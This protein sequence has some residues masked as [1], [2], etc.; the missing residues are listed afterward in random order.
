MI[1]EKVIDHAV[2]TPNNIAIVDDK[3][4]LTYRELVYGANLFVDHLESLAPRE[5]FGE[6]VGLLIPPTAA[7]VVAFGG[8]RWADRVALPLNYLLKPDELVGVVK[9]AGLKILFTIEFFKPLAEAVA[10]QTGV[11]VVYMESL[12][13]EK[14]GMAVM[15]SIAMS[16]ANLRKHLKP[17]PARKP[18]DV[19]VIMYTSGTSGVPKGVMLT[20][21]NLESNARD[22]CQHA[23]F[24]EKTVF[25]GVIP[26]FHTLGMMGTML[27]PLMLGSKVVYIARFSPM[28]VF[29][30]VKQHGIEVL[31]MVPTMYAVMASAK[32]A[33]P[34]SLHGVRYVISGGE[35]LP[36]T[37]IEQFKEKFNLTLMEGFG[38]TETSPIVALNVPWAYKLGSVGKIIPEVQVK[39]VDDQ[40][41]DLPVNAD[42]GELYIK[43]PNV[44][45][46]YYNRPEVTAEVMTADGWFKT[47]DIAKMDNEG[48]LYITGRKKDMI[49]M[50]GEKVFPREI[51]DAIKQHPAVLLV[52]VIGMKDE[53]RGEAPV[54]FVQLKPEAGQAGGNL[55]KPT[56]QEIRAF[57]RERIAPY[58]TPRDV[59]FLDELP[60]TPT[61]KVLKR[62]LKVPG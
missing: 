62:A 8:T 30:S 9:D 1:L 16:A 33:R 11:K 12:K 38:L 43:G 59:Y 14:P 18:N 23:R 2:E 32:A 17:L 22:S 60:T 19:A 29:D 52:G 48:F 20:N 4:T 56:A 50:A 26:M 25:L 36:V 21:E 15:A 57:V 28:G 42:G 53:S 3:R 31:I 37:L 27:I 44:M 13:F 7:F 41:K 61:G 46:G 40:G 55:P 35:P 10:G 49:I 5:Q 24:N 6:K 45:K 39:T 54:A 47:G 51:E 34:E 58:K